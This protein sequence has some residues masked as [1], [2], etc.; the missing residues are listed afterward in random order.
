[1]VVAMLALVIAASGVAVAA[2]PDTAGEISG[3]YSLRNGALRVINT[4]ASPPE[5]CNP[6]KELGVSWSKQGPKGDQGIQGVK[7]D[8]GLPGDQGPAGPSL[9]GSSCTIPDGAGGTAGTVAMAVGSNGT[10]TFTCNALSGGGGTPIDCDDGNPYTIDSPTNSGGCTHT[11][12][13]VTADSDVDGYV[14][15][16]AGGDDCNDGD[17]AINP[18]AVEIA[19]D[20]VDNDCDGAVDEGNVQPYGTNTGECSEGLKNMDTGQIVVEA[21]GPVEEIPDN[22]LDEDC[23][24][25][26]DEV[27]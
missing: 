6:T 11:V 12:D 23:D 10:I 4:E 3:C 18:G 15:V 7:G 17:A 14:A 21:I 13:P 2:I 26:T 20:G 24:G 1:M 16:Q 19:G 27:T 9:V 8:Q 25:Q 22:G 5:T